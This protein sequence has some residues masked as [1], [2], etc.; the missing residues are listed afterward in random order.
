MW[1]VVITVRVSNRLRCPPFLL[2]CACF[3]IWPLTVT[4]QNSPGSADAI[5][6][7]GMKALQGGDL[8]EA[9]SAFEQAV[10][11]APRSPD[12]HNSLGWVLNAQG[13]AHDAVAEFQTALR[14]KPDFLQAHI[15]LANP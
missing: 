12:A 10:K 9:R 5:Y 3:C 7:Q 14:L 13:Q 2:S 8:T 11:L 1:V 4:G 6:R 15:N